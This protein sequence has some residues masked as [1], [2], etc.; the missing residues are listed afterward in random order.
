M[1]RLTSG[2]LTVAA[3]GLQPLCLGIAICI[4][5][6]GTLYPPLLAPSGTGAG[7]HLIACLML[8]A[9]TSGFVRGVGFA[10][11]SALWRVLLSTPACLA[12]LALAIGARAL[13]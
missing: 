8:W 12:S 7:S 3:P 11:R 1:S 4:M 2:P 9:M 5:L 13:V 10:P 6:G